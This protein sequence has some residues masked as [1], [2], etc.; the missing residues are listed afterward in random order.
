M[1]A[2]PYQLNR[3]RDSPTAERLHPIPP[4]NFFRS[5]AKVAAS[6]GLSVITRAQGTGGTFI[7]SKN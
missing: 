4:E 7:V 5:F 2:A 1:E 6:K 3:I